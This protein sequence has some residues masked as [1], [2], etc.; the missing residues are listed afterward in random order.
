[1]PR[2]VALE[3][4][5]LPMAVWIVLA[6]VVLARLGEKAARVWAARLRRAARED[7]APL[8]E[9][10]RAA[11]ARA[12]RILRVVQVGEKLAGVVALLGTVVLVS[13]VAVVVMAVLLE[14]MEVVARVI[15]TAAMGYATGTSIATERT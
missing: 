12:A 11:A 2:P 1:M 15:R 13:V 5:V 3:G 6:V 8:L 9:V 14:V 10:E 7:P 4:Q